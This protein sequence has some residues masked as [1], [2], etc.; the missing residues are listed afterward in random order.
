MNENYEGMRGKIE[1][2]EISPN[3]RIKKW[4]QRARIFIQNR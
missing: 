3:K 2:I 1:K 4:N